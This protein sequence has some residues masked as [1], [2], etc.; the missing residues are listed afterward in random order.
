M[1]FERARSQE[2][3]ELRWQQIK[4][5]AKDM[6]ESMPYH[7]I[8][9]SK[10]G[11]ELSFDRANLYKYARTK[12]A[13]YIRVFLD[14]YDSYITDLGFQLKYTDPDDLDQF[15]AI[16]ARTV[17]NYP[18]YLQLSSILYGILEQNSDMTT[19]T[20]FKT[21]YFDN[22]HKL[23]LLFGKHLPDFTHKEV[24]MF[25]NY[26]DH[27]LKG[28]Y[29]LTTPTEIQSGALKASGV[30]YEFPNLE[31]EFKEYLKIVIDGILAQRNA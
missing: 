1:A 16:L 7:E 3:K 20:E 4:D 19:M 22:V 29:P 25:L 28:I 21:H 30:D 5:T 12:E 17:A 15:I 23:G 11:N 6:L 14:D 10:I 26:A 18:I 31:L 13:I 8:T 27:F 24:S 2:N 9:F